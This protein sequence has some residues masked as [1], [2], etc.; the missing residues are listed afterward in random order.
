MIWQ[1]ALQE[2]LCV[3]ELNKSQIT[4]RKKDLKTFLC[5]SGSANIATQMFF[6]K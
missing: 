6:N 1:E 5:S 2:K 4:D 3:K